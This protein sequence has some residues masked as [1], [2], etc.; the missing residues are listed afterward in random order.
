MAKRKP[1]A[2]IPDFGSIEQAAG[3]VKESIDKLESTKEEVNAC[4]S[5][6]DRKDTNQNASPMEAQSVKSSKQRSRLGRVPIQGY[7]PEVTRDRLKFLAL[8]NKTTVESLM[9]DAF[10]RFFEEN[11]DKFKGVPHLEV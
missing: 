6:E 10:E 5:V 3:E 2:T 4:S 8:R 9:S 1:M 7:F 11:K